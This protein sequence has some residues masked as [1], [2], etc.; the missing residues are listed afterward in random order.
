MNASDHEKELQREASLRESAKDDKGTAKD[1]DDGAD[2][3]FFRK[4]LLPKVRCLLLLLLLQRFGRLLA[5]R[6]ECN[7]TEQNGNVEEEK[8]QLSR[9]DLAQLS[10]S[11]A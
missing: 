2:G 1:G 5:C 8:K 7:D 11:N 6:R 9:Q 4:L 10:L 3:A